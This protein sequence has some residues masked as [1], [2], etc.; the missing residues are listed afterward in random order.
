MFYHLL[1][2]KSLKLEKIDSF[3]S[4]FLLDSKSL[5]QLFWNKQLGTLASLLY[6]LVMSLSLSLSFIGP[7]LNIRAPNQNIEVAKKFV[8][9]MW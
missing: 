2:P 1:M 8:I 3:T 6:T 9:D 5:H 4:T 7:V